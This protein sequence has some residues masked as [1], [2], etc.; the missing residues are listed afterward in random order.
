[1]KFSKDLTTSVLLRHL[2]LVAK[3]QTGRT[4]YSARK[5]GVASSKVIQKAQK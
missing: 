2:W 4:S 3:L 1:M 5:A